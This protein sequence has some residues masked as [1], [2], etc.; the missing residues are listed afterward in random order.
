MKFRRVTMK[1]PNKENV[2][3][4]SSKRPQI[5]EIDVTG[6][7]HIK[8]TILKVSFEPDGISNPVEKLAYLSSDGCYYLE[9]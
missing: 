3:S 4:P 9:V 6:N 5:V 8:N 7:R 1:T 2:Y